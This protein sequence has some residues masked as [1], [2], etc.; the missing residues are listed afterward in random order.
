MYIHF[1]MYMWSTT[2]HDGPVSGRMRVLRVR[3][4]V[5][6]P[7]PPGTPP[8]SQQ[9]ASLGARRLA[10]TGGLCSRCFVVQP[11]QEAEASLRACC[12]T[13]NKK[14]GIMVY[15]C[16]CGR[17]FCSAHRHAEHHACQFDYKQMARNVICT[18]N[19]AV[20]TDKVLR[21]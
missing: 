21:F 14:M 7:H 2:Q 5:A 3:F 20:Q 18:E 13:C 10:S 15:T 4:T 17:A 8:P 12:G 11:V 1:Q 19:P 16:K 6:C 9:D